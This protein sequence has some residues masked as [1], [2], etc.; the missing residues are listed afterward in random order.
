M[1]KTSLFN[2]LYILGRN[3]DPINYD[4]EIDDNLLLIEEL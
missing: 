3:C 4:N 1:L 2:P